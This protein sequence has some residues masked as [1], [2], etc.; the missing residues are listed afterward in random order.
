MGDDIGILN[1]GAKFKEA[2]QRARRLHDAVAVNNDKLTEVVK[3][4]KDLNR[5]FKRLITALEKKG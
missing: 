3:E 2:D 1:I 5:N 4:L